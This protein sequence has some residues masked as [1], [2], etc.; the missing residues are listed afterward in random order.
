MTL[1]NFSSTPTKSVLG[2]DISSTAVKLIELS[3]SADCYKINACHSLPL[4]INT[5]IDKDITN[6]NALAHTLKQLVV[7]SGTKLKNIS[8]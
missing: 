2:L 6:V 1:F 7:E 5:M 3:S 8:A 4:P